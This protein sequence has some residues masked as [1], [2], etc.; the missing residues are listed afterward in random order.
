VIFLRQKC[1]TLDKHKCQTIIAKI[2]ILIVNMP[3]YF[4]HHIFLNIVMD[5]WM[6]VLMDGW[7][8]ELNG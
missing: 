7:M 6:D 1:L 8:D 5:G 2:A 4:I 3:Q